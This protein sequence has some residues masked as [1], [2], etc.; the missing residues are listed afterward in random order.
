MKRL[1]ICL[2]MAGLILTGCG[3]MKVYYDY[4]VR[5]EN[6]GEIELQDVEITS[7][8]GFWFGTGYVIKG[9]SAGIGSPQPTP[10][11]D[12]Y[13]IALKRADGTTVTHTIDMRDKV[14]KGFR[15]WVIFTVNDKNEVGYKLKEKK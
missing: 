7:K 11:N 8:N 14:E 12:I 15:G 4:S 5:A 10:P 6:V 1:L 13:T 2:F 9:T 3:T